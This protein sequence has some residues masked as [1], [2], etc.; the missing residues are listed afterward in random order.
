[1]NCFETRKEFISFWRRTL[2]VGE[3]AQFSAHLR[4]CARCD[5]SFRV[6]ALTA[7]ALHSE[8]A[9]EEDAAPY[10]VT[11]SSRPPTVIRRTTRRDASI[12]FPWRVM[13]AAFAMAAAAAVAVYV[14]I[15][16]RLTFEDAIAVENPTV[17]PVSYTVADNVF[18]QE[19]FGQDLNLQESVYDRVA[20]GLA[21]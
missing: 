11:A 8:T 20:D 14:A 2:P 13:T 7:P 3:R 17:E 6:F 19:V 1:M 18:G 16:S 5:R 15:P 21:E 9:P 4:E 12:E 10:H